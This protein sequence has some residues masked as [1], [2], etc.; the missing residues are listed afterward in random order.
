MPLISQPRRPLETYCARV[1][2]RWVRARGFSYFDAELD[3]IERQCI[4]E[5]IEARRVKQ[6]RRAANLQALLNERGA[7]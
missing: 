1:L 5:D 7:S 2:A 3:A 4:A 6:A